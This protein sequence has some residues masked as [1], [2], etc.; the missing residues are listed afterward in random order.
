MHIAVCVK[1]VVTRETH[2][3]VATDGTVTVYSPAAEITSNVVA[4]PKSTAMT[5]TRSARPNIS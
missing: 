1:Q 3:R 5:G 2:V 4:V